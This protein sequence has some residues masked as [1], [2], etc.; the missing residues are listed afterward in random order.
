MQ[1]RKSTA[2]RCHSPSCSLVEPS[3]RKRRVMTSKMMTIISGTEIQAPMRP[4]QCRHRIEDAL[5][6]QDISHAVG[7]CRPPGRQGRRRNRIGSGSGASWERRDARAC[8]ARP[9]ANPS[10]GSPAPSTP[11]TRRGTPSRIPDLGEVRVT[12]RVLGRDLVPLLLQRVQ[13]LLRPAVD[14]DALLLELGQRRALDGLALGQAF[15]EGIAAGD[16]DL[17]PLGVA[18]R[19]PGGPAS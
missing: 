1:S 15:A 16:L 3:T 9:R 12:R 2:C 18:Q 13:D 7:L 8:C 14:G 6:P 4:A 5:N 17:R 11:R 10:S 19:I